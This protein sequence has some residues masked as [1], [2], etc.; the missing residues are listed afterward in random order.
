MNVWK[1]ER[2]AARVSTTFFGTRVVSTD[3]VRRL[4]ANMV[5]SKRF[6]VPTG[7]DRRRIDAHAMW[8]GAA[9][10]SMH[11]IEL[12]NLTNADN[13]TATAFASKKGQ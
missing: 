2:H 7:L 8:S 4:I 13:S 5:A 11:E 12:R 1:A 9:I 3:E 10:V 6:N